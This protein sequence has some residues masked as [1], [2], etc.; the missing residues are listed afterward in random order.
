MTLTGLWAV[1]DN[2]LRV[3]GGALVSEAGQAGMCWGGRVPGRRGRQAGRVARQ[4]RL[5]RPSCDGGVGCQVG[6]ASRA[7]MCLGGWGARQA[8]SPGRQGRPG[9]HVHEL[10]GGGGG[11]GGGGQYAGQARPAGH[12]VLGGW[13]AS[14]ARP[15]GNHVHS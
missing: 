13:R 1:M 12:H 3:H 7:I 15:A 6:E 11:G 2:E 9:R 4:A 5:V 14:Q 10:G 8:R